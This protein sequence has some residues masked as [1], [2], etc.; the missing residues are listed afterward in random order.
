MDDLQ[1]VPVIFFIHRLY[2]CRNLFLSPVDTRR[3]EALHGNIL[4]LPQSQKHPLF[5]GSGPLPALL[6]LPPVLLSPIPDRPAEARSP[7]PRHLLSPVRIGS[8]APDY[9]RLLLCPDPIRDPPGLPSQHKEYGVQQQ[10]QVVAQPVKDHTA[11]EKRHPVFP[12]CK[13]ENGRSRQ[14]DQ[15]AVGDQIP[16]GSRLFP[17][18]CSCLSPE[19]ASCGSRWIPAAPALPGKAPGSCL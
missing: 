3:P 9:L 11:I 12:L 8:P 6:F 7:L 2:R 18:A 17:A 4:S 10:D 1:P 13:A 15:N 19:T 5:E 16:A 14:K